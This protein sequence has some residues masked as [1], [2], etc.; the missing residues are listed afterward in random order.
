[1]TFTAEA[2]G[3]LYLKINNPPANL[4]DAGGSLALQIASVSSSTPE[5]AESAPRR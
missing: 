4:S 5:K 3:P 1:M 2:T